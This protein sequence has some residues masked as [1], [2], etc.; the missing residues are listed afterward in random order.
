MMLIDDASHTS[1]I[2]SRSCCFI[3]LLALCRFAQHLREGRHHTHQLCCT[4]L[5]QAQLL[6]AG[7][8]LMQPQLPGLCLWVQLAS[9]APR[10]GL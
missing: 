9:L 7:N 1:E 2:E 5:Q 10:A 8:D 6:L 3:T 4:H